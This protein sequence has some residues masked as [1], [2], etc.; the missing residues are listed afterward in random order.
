MHKV[1]TNIIQI[2]GDV[3]TVEAEGVGNL[4]IAQITTSRG[5]SLAQVIR[6]DEKK[7]SLQVFAGSKGVSTGDK[8]RFLGHQ[9][10]VASG[11]NLMGRIFNGSG[12]PLDKG[13]QLFDNMVETGK[14]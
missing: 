5:T 11:D 10:Q 4:E 12:K 6:I 8:V 1:Y 2:A 9:M 13:P 7:I 14:P 3:I